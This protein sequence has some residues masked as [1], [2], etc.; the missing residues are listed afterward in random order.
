MPFNSPAQRQV[1]AGAQ[2]PNSYQFYQF[3]GAEDDE[4]LRSLLNG[5]L[6]ARPQRFA[7]RKLP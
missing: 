2:K 4:E 6:D 5:F 7:S 3:L 1:Q